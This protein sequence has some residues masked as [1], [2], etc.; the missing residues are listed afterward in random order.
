MS[1]KSNSIYDF[2]AAFCFIIGIILLVSS[3]QH[4][5]SLTSNP[6]DNIIWSMFHLILDQITIVTIEIPFA[7]GIGIICTAGGS[8]SLFRR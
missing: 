8:V 2:L 5:V 7:G 4:L 1:D 3:I 6:F